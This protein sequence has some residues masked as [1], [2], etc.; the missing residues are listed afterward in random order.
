MSFGVCASRRGEAFDYP[1]VFA[2]AD[3]AL[4]EAKHSGRDRVCVAEDADAR[5]AVPV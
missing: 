3:E 1:A 4:Y 2:R 5:I